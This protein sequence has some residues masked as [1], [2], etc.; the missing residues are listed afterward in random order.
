MSG[1]RVG[2]L[3]TWLLACLLAVLAGTVAA[4]GVQPVPALSARV[5]DQTATL[6]AAARQALETRLA[7]FEA[8]RGTQIVI[9]IVA[10]TAPEDI[11]AYAHRVAD[12]WKIGR[13]EVGDGLLLVVAKE[14][15]TVRIEV[16][17]TLEG[18]VPD[19]AAYRIIDRLVTPAFRQGDFAGGLDAAVGAL[20]ALIRGE[21][22]PLPAAGTSS[23]DMSWEDI[24]LLLFVAVPT[25][26]GFLASAIGRKP[27]LLVTGGASGVLIW[28]VAGSVLLG[29]I[30]GVLAALFLAALGGGGGGGGGPGGRLSGPVITGRRGGFGGSGGGFRSGGGGSFGGGGASGR[31]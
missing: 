23:A 17:R 6:D 9:L 24:L 12:T 27:A 14:D 16:A 4:Q 30:G 29:I 15:R 20:D 31:W 18:A 13:A 1:P 10:T 22:L 21:D 2:G 26:G 11:A 5:I 3:L 19:L 25:L 8:E 7:A 28:L